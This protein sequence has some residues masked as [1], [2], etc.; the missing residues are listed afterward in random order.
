MIE[1]PTLVPSAKACGVFEHWVCYDYYSACM[2]F[3]S[4][5]KFCLVDLSN[6]W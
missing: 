1:V 5:T 6:Y 4:I 3:P 2:V